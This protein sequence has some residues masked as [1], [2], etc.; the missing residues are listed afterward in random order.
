MEPQQESETQDEQ[1]KGFPA[2]VA[3]AFAQALEDAEAAGEPV[4]DIAAAMADGEVIKGLESRPYC[5]PRRL[6]KATSSD[7]CGSRLYRQG[8]EKY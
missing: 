6:G 8:G 7:E 4:A 5:R 2:S 1:P 3:E